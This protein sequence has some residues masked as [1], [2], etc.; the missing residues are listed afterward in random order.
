[1]ESRNNISRASGELG[2]KIENTH[3][4]VV[5]RR[6]IMIKDQKEL[7][8]EDMF[9]DPCELNVRL[10]GIRYDKAI[11]NS[12]RYRLRHRMTEISLDL[13]GRALDMVNLQTSGRRDV[14]QNCSTDIA[15]WGRRSADNIRCPAIDQLVELRSGTLVGHSV[16]S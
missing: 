5:F 10:A 4:N 13:H 8:S 6:D 7:T 9:V 15:K 12:F 3:M 11:D 14:G 16:D 2:P 1:M